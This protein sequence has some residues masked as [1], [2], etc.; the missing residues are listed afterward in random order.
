[1]TQKDLDW[2]LKKKEQYSQ[3]FNNAKVLEI[4]SQNINGTV[5]DA[6]KDCNYIGVDW[7]AGK[8]VNIICKA[9]ET[10]FEKEYFD[11]FISFST[12]EH[13][14]LW[15]EDIEHNLS[16]LKKGGLIL[17]G[18]AGL[19]S[20]P[21]GTE[22]SIYGQYHPKSMEEMKEFLAQLPVIILDTEQDIRH[23]SCGEFLLLTAIKNET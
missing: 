8:D 4:G 14:P 3:Y 23:D 19:K 5:R 13:D 20:I 17:F 7:L 21:H 15:K 16:F 18:W 6:F 22:W 1:M 11:T 12:W 2:L 9:N 10:K